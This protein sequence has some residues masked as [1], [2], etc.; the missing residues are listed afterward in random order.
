[1]PDARR[2][3]IHLNSQNFIETCDNLIRIGQ[4][5]QAITILKGLQI[6][7]VPRPYAQPIAHL[8]YR[9]RL[10]DRGLQLLGPCVFPGSSKVEPAKDLEIATFAI[11]LIKI[12]SV[13]EGKKLLST[14]SV[15]L[16]EVDLYRAFAEQA[17]WNYEG[18]VPYLKKYLLHSGLNPYQI[19]I[20]KVN[21][22]ASW[23][24]LGEVQESRILLEELFEKSGNE[25]LS[26]IRRNVQELWV[27]WA[28]ASHNVAEA[29]QM[30]KRLRD[31]PGSK[32]FG[33]FDFFIDKWEAIVSLKM[34]SKNPENQK[35]LE[36]VR[37]KAIHWKHWETVRACDRVL[38]VE[39][40]NLE[41]WN[42][43]YFGTPYW[44]YKQSLA[45]ESA[46]WTE[47]TQNY[48]WGSK[49]GVIFDIAKA[50]SNDLRVKLKA[51][52][53][54]HR[55]LCALFSDQYRP[56]HLT[57][58][59]ALI[60]PGET[61][62]AEFSKGRVAAIVS[63]LRK[64]FEEN[65]LPLQI[66]TKGQFYRL[67]FNES[68]SN[69]GFRMQSNLALTPSSNAPRGSFLLLLEKMGS[70]PFTSRE[71]AEVLN[72]SKSTAVRWL[73]LALEEGS[74]KCIGNNKTKQY[75]FK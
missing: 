72:V 64:W 26:L 51:G 25:D 41:L 23:I 12:G 16:P 15:H 54:L 55:A 21:L 67:V 9:T 66:E 49:D 33:I 42:K 36:Q 31:N 1:M 52:Q 18:A 2:I 37:V 29:Q 48:V 63:R 68:A 5:Q 70:S 28:V 73:N 56:L 60:F 58:L 35:S 74:L 50:V 34:D 13:S 53:G 43:V 11:L 71:A 32:A 61:F 4:Y 65:D 46:H 45:R 19:A 39:T 75:R 7:E 38:A 44:A 24:A 59:F 62:I 8:F 3:G 69:V 30:L 20:A 14:L 6:K 27:Q 22:A 57:E 47:P 10:F 40:K 17:E